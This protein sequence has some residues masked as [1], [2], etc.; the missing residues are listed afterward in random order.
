MKAVE[1]VTMTTTRASDPLNYTFKMYVYDGYSKLFEIHSF[2]M[3]QVVRMV[4]VKQV[5]LN[6]RSVHFELFYVLRF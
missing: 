6:L 3:V 1:V 5:K 2:E 4:Q